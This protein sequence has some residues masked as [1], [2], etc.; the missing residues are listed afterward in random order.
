MS[1]RVCATFWAE[2]SKSMLL[3]HPQ[4]AH[5]V[6]SLCH[7][8]QL[9]HLRL[10]DRATRQLADDLLLAWHTS[11]FGAYYSAM[12]IR[13]HPKCA[14]RM[15]L[16]DAARHTVSNDDDDDAMCRG[17]ATLCE[18]RCTAMTKRGSV[19]RRH[20]CAHREPPRCWQ[21]AAFG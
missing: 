1:S 14:V 15:A 16:R 2:C 7:V 4:L 9:R 20:A 17:A 8:R 5:S 21:H 11:S 13:I 12:R 6:L 10:I 3:D 18:A 19:C